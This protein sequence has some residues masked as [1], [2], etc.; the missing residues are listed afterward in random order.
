MATP[1]NFPD[2]PDI[3]YFINV[4]LRY[5]FLALVKGIDPEVQ[6]VIPTRATDDRF[7]ISLRKGKIQK[8]LTLLED[9]LLDFP[10]DTTIRKEVESLVRETLEE[11]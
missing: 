8:Y 1:H 7:L 4:P 3:D 2:S 6:V 11:L 10:R 5:E 9:D